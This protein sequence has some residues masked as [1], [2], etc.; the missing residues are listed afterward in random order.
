[1]IQ[2]SYFFLWVRYCDLIVVTM[3]IDGKIFHRER[4]RRPFSVKYY[5]FIKVDLKL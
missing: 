3:G 1:M 5:D 2:S 4:P